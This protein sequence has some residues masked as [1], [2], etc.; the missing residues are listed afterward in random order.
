[1][2]IFGTATNNAKRINQMFPGMNHMAIVASDCGDTGFGKCRTGKNL[3]EIH[4]G[5]YSRIHVRTNP[6]PNFPTGR[7]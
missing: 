5:H 7:R 4:D 2:S 3:K 6:R 1:M